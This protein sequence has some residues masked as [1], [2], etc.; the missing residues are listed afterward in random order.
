MRHEGNYDE[1][2]VYEAK[3]RSKISFTEIYGYWN[4]LTAPYPRGLEG[5]N[6]GRLETGSL[7]NLHLDDRFCFCSMV[8]VHFLWFKGSNSRLHTLNKCLTMKLEPSTHSYL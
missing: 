5:S 1:R 2:K 7:V 3:D 4:I 8:F 6:S